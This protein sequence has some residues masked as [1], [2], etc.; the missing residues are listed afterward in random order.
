MLIQ[1]SALTSKLDT[2]LD[3]LFLLLVT[4]ISWGMTS[5]SGTGI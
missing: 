2:L 5:S 1:T 4:F 3:V